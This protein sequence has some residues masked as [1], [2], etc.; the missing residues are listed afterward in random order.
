MWC[1]IKKSLLRNA[2]RSKPSCPHEDVVQKYFTKIL[3]KYNDNFIKRKNYFYFR[4][5]L[6]SHEKWNHQLTEKLQKKLIET[7]G[8]NSKKNI[9]VEF[10]AYLIVEIEEEVYN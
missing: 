10:Y 3:Q 6:Q 1:C 5:L 4:F 7:I 2:S 9:K 8:Y